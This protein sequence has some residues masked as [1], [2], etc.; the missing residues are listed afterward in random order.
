MGGG[1][2]GPEG[3]MK[4]KWRD[5]DVV[6]RQRSECVGETVRDHNGGEGIGCVD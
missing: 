5:G 1:S 3:G 4:R 2:S 6:A